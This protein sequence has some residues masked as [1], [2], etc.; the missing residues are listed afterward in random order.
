MKSLTE[1][2]PIT[3]IFLRS[4]TTLTMIT[5]VSNKSCHNDTIAEW[6]QVAIVRDQP[7]FPAGHSW[8]DRALLVTRCL[9]GCVQVGSISYKFYGYDAIDTKVNVVV[10]P[11]Q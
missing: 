7:P 1:V 8:Q 5:P 4:V 11:S 3:L 9:I 6:I 10:A 2:H